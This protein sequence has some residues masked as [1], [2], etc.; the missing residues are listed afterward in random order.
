MP[1]GCGFPARTQRPGPTESHT[2]SGPPMRS[3]R[4]RLRGIYPPSQ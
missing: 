1:R 3:D 2:G 4:G